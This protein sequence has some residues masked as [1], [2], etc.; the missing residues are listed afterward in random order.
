MIPLL[1]IMAQTVISA[2]ATAASWT[3]PMTGIYEPAYEHSHT[4]GQIFFDMDEGDVARH[5][6]PAPVPLDDMDSITFG[7]IRPT[8]VMFFPPDVS[9]FPRVV[10]ESPLRIR[11]YDGADF[12]EY[13]VPLYESISQPEFAIELP[14]IDA[15]EFR[16]T[17]PVRFVGTNLIAYRQ[18]HPLDVAE[19]V[20]D[21]IR[22]IPFRR[23]PAGEAQISAGRKSVILRGN[24]RQ[25]PGTV[26]RCGNRSYR[27]DKRTDRAGGTVEM[28][29]LDD[30]PVTDYDGPA[31][32][33]LPVLVFPRYDHPIVPS[34]SIDATFEN[35]QL[36]EEDGHEL[37]IDSV[38]SDFSA[39]RESMRSR[40]L[41]YNLVLYCP[42]SS[43]VNLEL[44]AMVREVFT[45]LMHRA[46]Y[47][48]INGRPTP[49]KFT[50]LGIPQIRGNDQ[51]LEIVATVKVQEAPRW[52]KIRKL[53]LRVKLS[54]SPS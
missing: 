5:A 31:Y 14:Q 21:L 41:T 36:P 47:C 15:V 51:E 54:S 50:D 25:T 28:T 33:D 46:Q 53:G 8:P 1:F 12:V 42:A 10:R 2:M 20:A 17:G 9:L 52:Q 35:G 24:G 48:Y 38:R 37:C 27:I 26:L 7:L 6:L 13:F 30:E 40:E 34:I 18:D 32:I 3:G 16:A 29:P 39:C 45:T 11:L 49:V 19:A 4:P 23:I 22:T 43:D 44:L